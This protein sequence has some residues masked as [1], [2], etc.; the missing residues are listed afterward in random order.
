M[1]CVRR[2]AI[3]CATGRERSARRIPAVPL[4]DPRLAPSCRAAGK[5]RCRR[6]PARPGRSRG[7]AGAAAPGAGRRGATAR[8]LPD[9]AGHEPAGAGTGWT[10]GRS[11]GRAPAGRRRLGRAL[12]A[13]KRASRR[14]APGRGRPA[15]AGARPAAGRRR[16]D[17]PGAVAGGAGV[18]RRC[19]QP[20]GAAAP[21]PG[22]G[23][24]GER[25]RGGPRRCCS[26]ISPNGPTR[27]W[28]AKTAKAPAATGASRRPLRRRIRWRWRTTWAKASGRRGACCRARCS[29]AW[30]PTACRR[31]PPCWPG[32]RSPGSSR[33]TRA[34]RW[35]WRDWS[36]GACSTSSPSWPDRS[37]GSRRCAWR[38]SARGSVGERL[39]ALQ[40]A[41]L[42]QEE[43]AALRDPFAPDWPLAEL[44]FAWLAGEL[45]GAGGGRAGLPSA[46]AGRVPRVAGAAPR[47]RPAGQPAG[48]PRP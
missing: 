48:P 21:R 41:I 14:C 43:A 38:M 17:A 33:A 5:Y 25:G 27:R 30:P 16:R 22:A 18:R 28:P 11:A 12:R 26:S 23:R 3:R 10:R 6:A 9:D 13:R 45:D 46:A 20:G 35:K 42:A 36:R 37:P 32:P 4:A 1:K 44:G 40:A 34:S 47:R 15:G 8:G 39:D 2:P 19:G 29:N 24:P 7:D 31:R